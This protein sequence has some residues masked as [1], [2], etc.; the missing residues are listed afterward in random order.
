VVASSHPHAIQEARSQKLLAKS[1]QPTW[2]S[3]VFTFT[4]PCMMISLL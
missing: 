3:L 1:L 2:D 4:R